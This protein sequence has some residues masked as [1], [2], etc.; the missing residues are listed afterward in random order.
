MSLGAKYRDY[1]A[2]SLKVK[3]MNMIKSAI[4]N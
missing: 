3:I 2:N 1:T 4:E